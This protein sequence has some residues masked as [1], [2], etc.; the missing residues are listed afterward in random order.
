MSAEQVNAAVPEPFEAQPF[1]AQP[2]EA[3]PF[4]AQPFEAQPFEAQPFEAQAFEAQPAHS[5]ARARGSKGRHA[6]PA[7]GPALPAQQDVASGF[8]RLIA[9]ARS[10]PLAT[11]GLAIL[12]ATAVFCFIGPVL[13][14]TDQVHVF[15][16]QANLAP[17]AGHPLG[18]DGDGND[19]L[20]RLMVGGQVSLE[21]GAAAGVLA[22]ILGSLWGAI[23]GYVGGYLDAVMMR[24]VDAGLAIPTVVVLLV[25]VTIYRPTEPVLILVIAA[26]SWLSTARLV[27]A[28]ALTL[29]TR[30]FVQAIRVMGGGSLRAVLRH[31][32]PNAFGTIV[33]NVSFQVANAVLTLA[34][35]SY[36]GLG[37][38]SPAVDWGDMIYA[39]VQTIDDGYWWQIV[40]PGLAIM[41]VVVAL[42]MLGDGL[43]D[44][45]G[46][47]SRGR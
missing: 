42:T 13:Y 24:V 4:E 43:R 31:I 35:L 37:I 12:V 30:E 7:V 17:G 46:R 16:S 28:E 2:F 1:E 36:L 34:I 11:V 15:L 32:A 3:Q 22:A 23:S 8:R 18:T 47:E 19:E 5:A 38:Q 26:T 27:R 10:M 21:V 40:A 14:H 45:L 25:V 9:T 29:R 6:G 44:G 33:V 20:G 41:L 39:A